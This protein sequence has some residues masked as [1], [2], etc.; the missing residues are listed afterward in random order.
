MASLNPLFTVGDQVAEPLPGARGSRRAGAWSR[1]KDLLKSVR[2]SAPE[3]RVGEY[4]HRCRAACASASWGDRDLLRS[5][6]ADRRRAHHEPRPHDPGPV[7]EP[8]AGPAAAARAGLDLHHPQPRHRGQDVRPGA[9]MYAGRLVEWGPV[10]RDLRRARPPV[11]PGAARLHPPNGRRRPRAPHR[12]R[13]PAPDL[14]P[15]RP[16]AP[17][18]PVPARDGPVPRA[19]AARDRAGSAPH[20]ALLALG[21]GSRSMTS[22][23]ILEAQN[24][25][26]ALPGE[27]RVFAKTLGVVRAVDGV[28]FSITPG[29]TL[30]LVGESGCG[31]DH[32]RQA[33]A[34]TGGAHRRRPA[35]RG[36]GD[37][38]PPRQ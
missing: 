34:A 10:T 12:H 7:P 36:P 30:G 28:S 9:V 37:R 2:I 19:G 35:L 15:R 33:G 22:T 8:P 11:H 13:G 25:T 3:S 21:A 14:A 16:A 31:K 6:A 4:P 17:S 20:H 23:P 26:Q 29:Q 1:A 24:L 32:H 38:G 5:P 27:A 18:I